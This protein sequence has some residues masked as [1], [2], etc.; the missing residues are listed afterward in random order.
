MPQACDHTA[1]EGR[2]KIGSMKPP[3]GT[4]STKAAFR[5]ACDALHD[6]SIKA[7]DTLLGYGIL[8][9]P[10]YGFLVCAWHVFGSAAR[11]GVTKGC[12]RLNTEEEIKPLLLGICLLFYWIY[13]YAK[14][15]FE[16]I[17]EL[18][19][20]TEPITGAAIKGVLTLGNLWRAFIGFAVPSYWIYVTWI[21]ME[22]ASVKS[23][24]YLSCVRPVRETLTSDWAFGMYACGLMSGFLGFVFYG[25]LI[26]ERRNKKRS[27]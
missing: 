24:F 21:G 16:S 1:C 5:D 17:R 7:W 25:A 3:Q 10:L 22:I 14:P 27:L 20:S 13:C 19:K 11:L 8:L 18:G 4:P 15:L 23:G 2:C 12:M 9:L 26:E 6:K